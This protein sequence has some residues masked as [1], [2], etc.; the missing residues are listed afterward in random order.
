MEINEIVDGTKSNAMNLV[1]LY[2]S[3]ALKLDI[4]WPEYQQKRHQKKKLLENKDQKKKNPTSDNLIE[5]K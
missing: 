1:E 2:T 4:V 3:R 5:G